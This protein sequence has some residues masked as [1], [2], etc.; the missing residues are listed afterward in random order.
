M[1][2]TKLDEPFEREGALSQV[3]KINYVSA[4]RVSWH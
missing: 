1:M 2:A 3:F 4:Y